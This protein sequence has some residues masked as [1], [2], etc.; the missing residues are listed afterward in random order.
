[1]NSLPAKDI[2]LIGVP[3]EAGTHCSGMSLAPKT[4]ISECDLAGRLRGEGYN[5]SVEEDILQGDADVTDIAKWR[6]SA[7][8]NG[9]RNEKAAL[10]VMQSVHDFIS[11]RYKVGRG[12]LGTTFPMF[13]SGDCTAG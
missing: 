11:C 10:R 4:I 6:P 2:V 7:K 8:I 13:I 1:M 3:N 5:V 9:V 12:D